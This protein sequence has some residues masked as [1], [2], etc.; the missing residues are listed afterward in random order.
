MEKNLVSLGSDGKLIVKS[1]DGRERPAFPGFSDPRQSRAVVYLLID[2]SSSMDGEKIEEIKGGVLD[3]AKTAVKKGYLVGLIVFH[4]VASYICEPT[5]DV[6]LMA[7]RIRGLRATGSTNLTD[8]LKVASR[9]LL[10]KTGC[11]LTVVAT[12]GCPND[13]KSA[14]RIAEEMKQDRIEILA[15]ATADADQ[16]FLLQ[17]VSRNDLNLKVERNEFGKGMDALARKLPN[18][19]LEDKT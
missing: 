16:N 12:D 2:C 4:D 5:R 1:T 19:L 10:K 13:P 7:E 11:R 17:L 3:F 9:M 14:L 15:I 8:A 18:Q 6:S